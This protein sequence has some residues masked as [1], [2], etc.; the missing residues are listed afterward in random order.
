M[1]A[2]P[3]RRFQGLHPTR[4]P[5]RATLQGHLAQHLNQRFN[6]DAEEELSNCLSRP[7]DSSWLL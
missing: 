2:V 3:V 7:Y 1:S 4:S 5:G 6:G